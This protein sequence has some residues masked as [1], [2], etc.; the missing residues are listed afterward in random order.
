MPKIIENLPERLTAEAMKQ[1]KE[2]GY[3]NMTI[4]TVAAGCGVGVGTV[5]NYFPSKDE[6]LAAC[7]MD[8]WK[9]CIVEIGNASVLH[10]DPEPVL[11]TMYDQLRLFA[12]RN[13]TVFQD[14]AAAAGFTGS[15]NR[16]HKQLRSHLSQ[17]LRKFCREDFQ[18]DF[19]AEALLTWTMARKEFDEIYEMIGKL[20]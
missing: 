16:Y 9:A 5:Y 1:I 15:F 19:I 2:Y 6:L 7:M 13:Q 11:R 3:G 17:P 20:F 10:S 12:G 4:R 14:P 18:A 8:D